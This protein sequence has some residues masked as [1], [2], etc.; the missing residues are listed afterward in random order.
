LTVADV[1][2]VFKDDSAELGGDPFGNVFELSRE[3][4]VCRLFN[5]E[6][7]TEVQ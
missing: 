1:A 5:S 4:I 6:D 3:S 7:I 2:S